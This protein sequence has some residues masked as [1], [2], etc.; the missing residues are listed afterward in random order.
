LDENTNSLIHIANLFN[1]ALN[2]LKISPSQKTEIA[3]LPTTSEFSLEDNIQGVTP[4]Y[5]IMS[6]L[7]RRVFS[8]VGSRFDSLMFSL[9]EPSSS[10]VWI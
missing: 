8:S 9:L 2:P 1:N 7:L 10:K 3:K 5:R 6:H 4:Y